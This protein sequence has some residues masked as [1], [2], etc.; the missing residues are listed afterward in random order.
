MERQRIEVRKEKTEKPMK[1]DG[2][3]KDRETGKVRR[4]YGKRGLGGFCQP[5]LGLH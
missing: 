2:D 1:D 3:A 5:I 4:N